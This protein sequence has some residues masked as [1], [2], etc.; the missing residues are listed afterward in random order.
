M[1][2][3]LLQKRSILKAQKVQPFQAKTSNLKKKE[4]K[5]LE[6]KFAANAKKRREGFV[7]KEKKNKKENLKNS[8]DKKNA[9]TEKHLKKDMKRFWKKTR[10]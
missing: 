3:K 6:R 7:K 8:K 9:K 10:E 5:E 1:L 4:P 2:N